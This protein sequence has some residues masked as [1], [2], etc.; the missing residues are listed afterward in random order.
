MEEDEYLKLLQRARSMIPPDAFNRDRFQVP[1][2][3]VIKEGNMTLIKNFFK[4]CDVINRSTRDLLKFILGETATSGSVDGQRAMLKGIFPV[5]K[6][7]QLLQR[8]VDAYVICPTCKK[9]D[10]R[11]E[12]EGRSQ[13]LVCAACGSRNA[14]HVKSSS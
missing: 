13:V 1:Q 9:P 5:K 3:E 6:L 8:Y 14:I 4:I 10:T 2:M 7:D 12:K 11:I